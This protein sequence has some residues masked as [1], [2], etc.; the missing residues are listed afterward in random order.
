MPR[1]IND[2]DTGKIQGR[3]TANSNSVS[4]ISPGLI[5]NSLLMHLDAGNYVSYPATGTTWFDISGNINNGTLT[6]GPTYSTEGNGSIAFT[7]TSANYVN[8]GTS[9]ILAD[10]WSI[11]AFIRTSGSAGTQFVMGRTAGSSGGFAQNYSLFIDS[12]NK[13]KVGSSADSYANAASTTTLANNTWYYILGTYN[14]AGK[15]LSIYVNGV[16]EAS[17]TLTTAPPTTAGLYTTLGAGDGLD[18]ANR[19]NGNIAF[20]QIYTRNLMTQE[21]L[22]NFNATRARFG[23]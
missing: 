11:G 23:V 4:I 22:Q 15:V 14:S 13:A 10:G 20:G 12:S 6:G 1:G 2:Y 3:N 7:T 9:L 17:T 16:F 21:V 8:C 18:A 19:L 5:T